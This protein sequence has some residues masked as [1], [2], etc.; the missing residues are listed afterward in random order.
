MSAIVTNVG[1]ILG[2]VTTWVPSLG[3]LLLSVPIL[4]LGVVFWVVGK[5]TGLF[6][7]LLG[8]S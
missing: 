4:A 7:S 6:G 5:T 1:T 3:G 2:G 8:K